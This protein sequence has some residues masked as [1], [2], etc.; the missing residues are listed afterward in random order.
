MGDMCLEKQGREQCERSGKCEFIATYNND[1]CVYD[2]TTSEPWLNAKAEAKH[3]AHAS[4]GKKRAKGAAN[5]QAAMLFGQESAVEQAM[6][7]Q[8]PLS[9]VLLFVVAALAVHQAYK[10]VA[11]R[12]GGYKKINAQRAPTTTLRRCKEKR[13]CGDGSNFVDEVTH[14]PLRLFLFCL[15]LVVFGCPMNSLLCSGRKGVSPV[16]VVNVL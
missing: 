3:A 4:K 2:T 7:Y 16:G 5:A 14:S 12:N 6:Q 9:T 13:K 11:N 15:F 10:C 8:V 1:D